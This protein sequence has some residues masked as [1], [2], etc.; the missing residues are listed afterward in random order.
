MRNSI[1]LSI[2]RKCIVRNN[3][4]FENRDLLVVKILLN[5]FSTFFSSDCCSMLKNFP[6]VNKSLLISFSQNSG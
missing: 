1:G 6:T 4:V 2:L 3:S 5:S